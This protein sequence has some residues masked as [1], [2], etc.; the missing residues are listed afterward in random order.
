MG[1]HVDS[2]EKRSRRHCVANITKLA[3]AAYG[4]FSFQFLDGIELLLQLKIIIEI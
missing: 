3:L 2:Q 4:D 1:F